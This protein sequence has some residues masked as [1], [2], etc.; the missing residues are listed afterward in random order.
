MTADF[1][2]HVTIQT[3]EEGMTVEDPIERHRYS[4]STRSAVDPVEVETDLFDVPVEKAVRFTT[5]GLELPSLVPVYVRDGAGKMLAEI[6]RLDSVSVPA[7]TYT[8][9][10]C[11]PIKLYVRVAGPVTVTAGFDEMELSF[12]TATSVGLG[13][14]SLHDHPAATITTVPT[15]ESV[16]AALS[17]FGSALQTTSPERSYPTLRGH[18]PLVEI[19]D[20]FH[21][22]SGLSVPETGIRIELPP[23]YD[24]VYPIASLAYYLG[25]EVVPGAE[26]RLLTN[27]GFEYDLEPTG[28][29]YQTE[30]ERVLKQVFFLDCLTRTEG[31]YT[32]DL[33]ERSLVGD[34]VDL[35]FATLYDRPLAD[36]LSVYLSVDYDTIEPHLPD[37]KLTTHVEPGAESV[38]TLPFLVDDLAIIRTPSS[39]SRPVSSIGESIVND[40]IRGDSFV[41]GVAS[42]RNSFVQPE[43]T[44]SLEQAWVGT[45]SPV[46]VSKVTAD[47]YRNRL[48]RAPVEGEIDITVVCND[49]RMAGEGDVVDEVYGS[50]ETLPYDISVHREL[51]VETLT[52][53]ITTPSEFL[54][55]IGHIDADGFECEDGKLDVT[56]LDEVGVDAFFLNACSSYDQGMALLDRGAIAGIVTLSDVINSGAVTIGRTVA[57]LLNA[58][59]PLQSALD[60]AREE[61][62]IG[63]WYLVVG[64]SGLAIAQAESGTPTLFHLERTGDGETFSLRIETF[65]TSER[66]MGSLFMPYLADND[67]HYLN[68]GE[69]REFEVTRDE[70]MEFLGYDDLPVR[71]EDGLRWSGELL[72]D[73]F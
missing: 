73:R 51:D 60:I 46:G 63:D 49:T 34:R 44:A 71:T 62:V 9:E 13:A 43:S 19:G 52:D 12:E 4:I 56:T 8:I 29:E 28:A 15:P 10:I 11:A 59:F 25:A 32:V 33:Y 69:L 35:D 42:T 61:S 65:P 38:E 7:G 1:P 2:A 24:Y 57:R 47:A 23:S 5:D 22:P 17:A 55:Y 26:P 53:V 18:P 68:S 41:R 40:F 27:S 58:G 64:D 16:M 30:V 36:Q 72:S 31:Y 14:R 54:H 39:K 6:E 70:L 20:E 66:G 50:Q 67:S 45:G 21:V 3:D 37:W 48:D